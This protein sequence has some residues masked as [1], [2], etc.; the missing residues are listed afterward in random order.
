M[1][2]NGKRD[3]IDLQKYRNSLHINILLRN[4]GSSLPLR[5]IRSIPLQVVNLRGNNELSQL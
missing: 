3:E 2:A 4:A 1:P 5:R